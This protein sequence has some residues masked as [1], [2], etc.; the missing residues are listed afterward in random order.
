[1]SEWEALTSSRVIRFNLF[2]VTA[3]PTLRPTTTPTRGHSSLG[4]WLWTIVKNGFLATEPVALTPSYSC[5]FFKKNGGPSLTHFY[6]SE[7]VSLALPFFRRRA[8]T[9]RPFLVLIRFRNPWSRFL[10]KFEGFRD[11]NDMVR[12]SFRPFSY[13]LTILWVNGMRVKRIF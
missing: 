8:R 5:F 13:E 6:S 1:M 3:F 11:V 7:T 9:F 12:F 4:T 2:L 10:F